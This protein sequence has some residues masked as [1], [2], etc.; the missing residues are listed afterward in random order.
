MQLVEKKRSSQSD[1]DGAF[2]ILIVEAFLYN[3][4]E[5]NSRSAMYFEV[6]SSFKS[7]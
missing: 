3:F 7:I 6:Q 2:L 5:G 1:V 4:V